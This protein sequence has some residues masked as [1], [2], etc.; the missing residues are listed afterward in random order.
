MSADKGSRCV[1]PFKAKITTFSQCDAGTQPVRNSVGDITKCEICPARTINSRCSA[2]ECTTCPKGT[3]PNAA[4]TEC[5][6]P[7]NSV[8]EQDS[9]AV[10]TACPKGSTK[11]DNRS[12][13]CPKYMFYQAPFYPRCGC[14]PQTKFVSGNCVPCTAA[15]IADPNGPCRTCNIDHFFDSIIMECV[16]CPSGTEK[17]FLGNAETCKPCSITHYTAVGDK[18]CG[19]PLGQE[20]KD[21]KCVPCALGT[22][23]GYMGCTKCTGTQYSD[24]VG[25]LECK[26]C[27]D[28]R[29]IPGS[30]TPQTTCPPPIKC[31]TGAFEKW[32]KCECK[33]DFVIDQS[34]GLLKCVA[35]PPK[36]HLTRRFQETKCKCEAG[37]T[38]GG[39]GKCKVCAPGKEPYR[40]AEC[41]KCRKNY[42]K[43]PGMNYCKPCPEGSYNVIKG[44]RKCVKCPRWKFVT[45]KGTCGRC[46]PGFRVLNGL[47]IACVNSVSRG[48]I[49]AYCGICPS[50]LK[51]NKKKS[52]CI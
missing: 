11:L 46:K 8:I 47:C 34:S 37:M 17:K 10:C 23:G 9:Y 42:Y 24:E 5:L 40:Y 35:C 12:C 29:G 14:R 30:N 44:S 38:F 36:S 41:R 20:E 22:A 49:S 51:P 21:N 25:L 48:G 1:V 50:A 15:E 7:G 18:K 45:K 26:T 27:S 13:K 43:A 19:C 32:G 33:D 31:Q 28:Y 4:R 3:S 6:C 39:N 52:R 16:P 2:T